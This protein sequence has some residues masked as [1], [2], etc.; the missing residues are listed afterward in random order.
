MNMITEKIPQA[1]R[2][3]IEG[4]DQS[5]KI[6]S[7]NFLK[8]ILDRLRGKSA[9]ET[10]AA[11]K[12]EI[13]TFLER[14]SA[15]QESFKS[16]LSGMVD[17]AVAIEGTV[18]TAQLKQK[19]Q[20]L[21]DRAERAY[22]TLL[23]KE[24][25]LQKQIT[26]LLEGPNATG[27]QESSLSAGQAIEKLARVEAARQMTE[28]AWDKAEDEKTKKSKYDRM[29]K[30]IKQKTDL[31]GRLEKLTHGKTHELASHITKRS[32]ELLAS[33]DAWDKKTDKDT[34]SENFENTSAGKNSIDSRKREQ[35][36]SRIDDIE[37][38]QTQLDDEIAVLIANDSLPDSAN[39]NSPLKAFQEVY[40]FEDR[41][42]K[43]ATNAGKEAPKKSIMTREALS[44]I[45]RLK[46]ELDAL[47]VEMRNESSAEQPANSKA[48]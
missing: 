21:S 13:D 35:Q 28:A 10:A 14:G 40:D 7:G 26:D 41:N 31:T 43:K 2:E 19:K 29:G 16:E 15:E 34:W 8:K 45:I 1:K 11:A 12:D 37:R 33:A 18:D 44:E 39:S 47:K 27:G 24:R 23:Q 38:I 25:E 6:D 9:S 22:T 42:I 20:E 48:A 30:L 4:A 46:K 36:E 17:K 5:K 3:Q 32:K